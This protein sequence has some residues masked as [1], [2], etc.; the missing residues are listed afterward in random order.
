MERTLSSLALV[1]RD[2]D[3]AIAFFTQALRFTLVE[4]TP[5]TEGKRWVVISPGEGGAAL[6]LAWLVAFDPWLVALSR[7]AD[8]AVLGLAL[9]LLA[10]TGLMRLTVEGDARSQQ[11]WRRWTAVVTGLPPGRFVVWGRTNAGAYGKVLVEAPGPQGADVELL[12]G[13]AV[14]LP[15]SFATLSGV[16]YRVDT[17]GRIDLADNVGSTFFRRLG[18]IYVDNW[19]CCAQ[20]AG[21]EPTA[22]GEQWTI[23]P[24]PIGGLELTRKVYRSTT[25]SQAGRDF[26]RF[27]DV[28]SNTS[29]VPVRV[30]VILS[31]NYVFSSY[32]RQV[33]TVPAGQAPRWG[34]SQTSNG[35]SSVVGEVLG[36][37]TV[38]PAAGW[39]DGGG[40]GHSYEGTLQP[41]ESTAFLRFAVVRPNNQFTVTVDDVTLVQAA[42][43][44][45]LLD[46][47]TIFERSL[48]RN[49]N[50]LP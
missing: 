4:D 19:F 18:D 6:V 31:S 46:G 29:A 25:S 22:G 26:V 17:R 5:Q 7:L 34:V 41:G 32:S 21:V 36:G 24:T 48:I 33:E 16:S 23:G 3:E 8:S 9:G 43:P 11:W 39:V 20:V 12:T 14:A 1:V 15:S 27:F 50:G 37:G 44:A 47:L 35:L 13:N 10:L 45:D 38:F 42:P 30:F 40:P 28:L 2:Y 49:W